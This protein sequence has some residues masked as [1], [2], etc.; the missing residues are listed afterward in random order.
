MLHHIA[1][2]AA[3]LGILLC[4]LPLALLQLDGLVGDHLRQL[5][6]KLLLGVDLVLL[7]LDLAV[8]QGDLLLQ[9]RKIVRQ[10][11]KLVFQLVFALSC[12]CHLGFQ[13]VHLGLGNG[14]DIQRRNQK[15]RDHQDR[16]HQRH[17]GD[18]LLPGSAPGLGRMVFL[19]KL[20]TPAGI[21]EWSGRCRPRQAPALPAASRPAWA[22]RPG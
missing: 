9:G 7:S 2:P 6:Q 18:D 10:A 3:Q 22:A 11:G 21:S 17:S 15:A 14:K 19:H 12:F 8:Q 5:R 13:G 20:L 16:H 4:L 1:Q